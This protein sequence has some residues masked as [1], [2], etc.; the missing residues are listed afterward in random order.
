[1]KKEERG[2]RFWDGRRYDRMVRRVVHFSDTGGRRKEKRGEKRKEKMRCFP[3]SSF[4]I[5]HSLFPR[6]SA[7]GPSVVHLLTIC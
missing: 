6:P 1:M 4:F 7:Y 2:K 5:P 3:R